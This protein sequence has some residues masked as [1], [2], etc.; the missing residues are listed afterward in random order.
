VDA[1]GYG[2][3]NWQEH[4]VVGHNHPLCESR[5]LLFIHVESDYEIFIQAV[6]GYRIIGSLR[7]PRVSTLCWLLGE[8][9]YEDYT[10]Y[11]QI[12]LC[13]KI[14]T[15]PYDDMHTLWWKHVV[16]VDCAY[17]NESKVRTYI[18]P[19]F[20]AERQT[21][22]RPF[23]RRGRVF[24]EGHVRNGVRLRKKKRKRKW[25][26]QSGDKRVTMNAP[27]RYERFVVPEGM[28]KQVSR[29][30]CLLPLTR[31]WFCG[32]IDVQ[33]TRSIFLVL[34]RSSSY[35]QLF[36]SIP[37]CWRGRRRHHRDDDD[38]DDFGALRLILMA[39]LAG[40]LTRETWR[41]WTRRPSLCSV[42]TIQL[43]MSFAC[44]N[45]STFQFSLAIF[46]F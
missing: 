37:E 10:K 22:I 14:H 38:D 4:K 15:I 31:N 42:R 30:R 17:N 41:L 16:P 35:S 21:L 2:L 28:K 24:A 19:F 39:L 40:S 46:S 12:V 9:I 23:W 1:K 44:L 43:G 45:L 32:R 25:F 36:R 33:K 5:C 26:A 6:K 13:E 8:V 11:I 18:M 20:Y 29:A 34:E 7:E 3:G 27:D